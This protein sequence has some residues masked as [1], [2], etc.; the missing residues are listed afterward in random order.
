MYLEPLQVDNYSLVHVCS[1]HS[2]A[3]QLGSPCWLCDGLKC[4]N[5]QVMVILHLLLRGSAEGFSICCI[6][7]EFSAHPNVFLQLLVTVQ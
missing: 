4:T 2:S 1:L 3:F 5:R 6:C 7:C